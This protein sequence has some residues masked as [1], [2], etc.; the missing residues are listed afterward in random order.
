MGAGQAPIA[1][2][3]EDRSGALCRH[4]DLL[5]A[6]RTLRVFPDA[7]LVEVHA[8]THCCHFRQDRDSNFRWCFAADIQTDWSVKTAEFGLRKIEHHQAL[9]PLLRVEPRA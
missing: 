4:A 8:V 6:L 9:M 2:F 5:I 3:S 1:G 7:D